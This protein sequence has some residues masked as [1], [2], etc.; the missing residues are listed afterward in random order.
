MIDQATIDKI[1]AA[2]DIVDVVSDFVSLRRR[3]ANYWG[4]CPF[5]D[6]KSPSFSVSP[7]K[8]VCKCFS[9]GKGGS[10]IHFIMEHE[11]LSYYEALKY[12]AKKY[13]IEV[14][15]KE[16][17]DEEKQKRTER[18]SMFVINAFAQEFFSHSLLETE[19]GRSV[20]M[21]YFR[22]RGFNEDIIRKFGLGYSP[23]KRDALAQEAKKRGYKTE[24]LLKTGLCREGQ[25]GSIYDLF[26]GRVMFPV[27]SVSGKVVA[28]GGRILKSGVKISKYF[29]SPESDIYHK[30]NELYGI[31]QAKRAIEKERCC[32][33]VEGYTDVLSMHQSG[34]ENVVASSGTALTPGQIRL[35][36]RFTDNITVLYDGDAPGIK[37]S[38][39][40]IDLILQEGLN[41]KVVLLPDGE[42]PDSFS[43][44]QSAESFRK[45][46]KEHET[47]FIRFKTQL[48]L[49]DAGEDP[50]K[51]AAII[52]NIVESI[53]LIP[54]A[55]VRSVYVQECSRL[56]QIDEQVLLSEL[57]KRR[58][59]RAEQ[60]STRERYQAAGHRPA[61]PASTQQPAVAGGN[62]SPAEGGETPPPHA[63][64]DIPVAPDAAE[65]A[66][67]AH[68]SLT[69]RV[70]SRSPLDKYEREIIRYIVR[71]GY[72]NLFETS[73]GSWQKVWEY[74]TDELSIDHI[75]LSN[76]L[77]KQIMEL[78]AAQREHEAQQA[79]AL[80]SELQAKS[81]QRIDEA[82]E[83]IR[84][85]SGDIAD[86]Q[87]KESEAQERI[88]GETDEELQTFET[89]F[90]E[91]YFTTYPDTT[92]SLLAVDLVSEKYQLSKVHTKFQ[93]IESETDRLW[94]L[95][96]RAIYELKN[97]ILDQ[98]IK[99]IQEQ[100]RE[101]SRNKDDKRVDELIEQNVELN[102]V[103][104]TLA[105]QIGDRIVSPK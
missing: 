43:K 33:L 77:Y 12:L 53:S 82:I 50:I 44:S 72:R 49:E 100:I 63:L 3:G 27:Y 9:C 13:N 80:R 6:D 98:A 87:R 70:A 16:L 103:R 31:Y 76:P 97:A 57:N 93:K 39:R 90:L 94:E 96:P 37:A 105:K 42:D 20:G 60:Q 35:I 2:T 68:D 84:L 66:P 25:H 22:E 74:I 36:H 91:R 46:I 56:L 32:Y 15:E 14:H 65:V 75:E 23:E 4:L 104:T 48:L 45:Y 34:I 40:G 8:G 24:F 10:A 1:M 30:S 54:D 102:Q 58:Q 59:K 55:I 41:I 78:T 64:T 26:A 99:Q 28:F 73:E 86:K 61:Q 88:L 29:N 92:I 69:Q 18:E 51:R 11:Q 5:H 47:D 83:Q 38:L 52:S 7:S 19:E 81:R 85:E 101:A 89:N 67:I 62:E 79:S 71:Y 17:T 95:I 21:A